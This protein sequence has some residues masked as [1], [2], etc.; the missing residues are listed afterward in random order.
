[1]IRNDDLQYN[2]LRI[3]QDTEAACFSEDAVLLT[4]FLRVKPEERIV[5]LGAGNGIISILGQAKTGAAFVGVEKQES[6]CSL[7]RQSAALNG[8]E[9]PFYCMDV[10]DAPTKLGRGIFSVAVMNP[11]YFSAGN[12]NINASRALARHVET[13][14]LNDFLLA[15]FHLL[16]N[17]GKLFLCYPADRL[18]DIVC[19]LRAH[20]LEPKHLR[21]AL[22]D[23]HGRPQRVLIQAKK[24]G[25]PGLV[26]E[27]KEF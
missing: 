20:R 19:A 24:D 13:G 9:I 22:P 4:D 11:P 2:G 8:Q 17:G 15:A 21:P 12:T 16:K 1:M 27:S 5:D 26:W 14:G 3:L 10:L 7:A 23:K 18:A 25:S 6:L